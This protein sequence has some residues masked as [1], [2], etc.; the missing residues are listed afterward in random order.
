[1]SSY[2]DREIV[3]SGFTLAVVAIFIGC[4]VQFTHRGPL[5]HFLGYAL[6][7]CGVLL[8]FL[9]HLARASRGYTALLRILLMAFAGA[10]LVGV[11]LKDVTEKLL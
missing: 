5:N 11:L 1:M 9:C 3:V 10:L 6:V 2:A 4:V 8:L 7:S